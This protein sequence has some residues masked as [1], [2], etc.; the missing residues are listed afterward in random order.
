VKSDELAMT[1]EFI[2]NMLGGRRESVTIAAGHLQDSGLIHYSRG[3]IRIIDR[4]GLEANVCECY[5]TVKNEL[6]RLFGTGRKAAFS[7]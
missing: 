5:Q 1:Q 6:D 4:K 3:H 2:A 7:S